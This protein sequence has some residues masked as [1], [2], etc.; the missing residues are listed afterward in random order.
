[1]GE[2]Y[3]TPKGAEIE[4]ADASDRQV[5]AVRVRKP[6]GEATEVE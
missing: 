4:I 6:S 3:R 2:R 5:R 1:V